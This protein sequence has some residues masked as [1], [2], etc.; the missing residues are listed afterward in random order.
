MNEA[1]ALPLEN[2]ES[3]LSLAVAVRDMAGGGDGDEKI[4]LAWTLRNRIEE[5]RP[6]IACRPQPQSAIPGPCEGGAFRP[7]LDDPALAEALAI[8]VAVWLGDLPDPT[9]GA[10]A[11]HRHDLQPGWAKFKHVKALIGE[12]LF[13]G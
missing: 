10:T 8:V 9:G 3:L 6:A 7:D 13:Y 4:A 5:R 1:V 11:C 12:Q 2:F